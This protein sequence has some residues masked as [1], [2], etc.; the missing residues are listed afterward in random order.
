[1]FE[2]CDSVYINKTKRHLLLRQYKHL[3]TSVLTNKALKYNDKH[4][5]VIRKRYH[6]HQHNSRLYNLKVLGNAIKNFR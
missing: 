3:G 1:M 4:T 6:Q 5:T 2:T